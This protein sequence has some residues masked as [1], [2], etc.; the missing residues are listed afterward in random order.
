M[1]QRPIRELLQAQLPQASTS[2]RFT[3]RTDFLNRY[4]ATCESH[5]IAL[6]L[7]A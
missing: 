2:L 3:Y 6:F 4:L 5:E 1:L 7:I